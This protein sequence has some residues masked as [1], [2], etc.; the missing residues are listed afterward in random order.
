VNQHNHEHDGHKSLRD[1]LSLAAAGALDADEQRLV[2][3]HLRGCSE[4]QAEFQ[5]WSR[6]AGGLRGMPVPQAPA[7]LVARTRARLETA[8]A[9]RAERWRNQIILGCLIL[10]AWMTTLLS[11]PV[12][13]LAGN[14]LA[15][16]LNMS[17]SG[18]GTGVAL[19]LV[20]GWVGTGVAAGLLGLRRQ[21]ER[22]TI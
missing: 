5:A 8:Q 17:T 7:G 20:L 19:Y 3:E 16:F 11:F 21:D 4:C 1:L 2:E 22:R 13:R 12:L 10:F 6:I 9:A 18:V 15:G 14:G